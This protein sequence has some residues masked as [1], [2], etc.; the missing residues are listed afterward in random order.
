MTELSIRSGKG[1]RP[2]RPRSTTIDPVDTGTALDVGREVQLRAALRPHR[3]RR[4]WAPTSCC[5]STTGTTA[6]RCCRG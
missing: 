1:I 5:A 6:G 2:P 3:P 4:T